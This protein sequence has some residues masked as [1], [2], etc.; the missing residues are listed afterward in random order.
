MS[1]D[2]VEIMRSLARPLEPL[3]TGTSPVLARLVGIRA[4]LLDVYGTLVISGSGDI[5][6]TADAGRKAAIEGA[7]A[8]MD[9]P[10]P[11]AANDIVRLLDETIRR[12]HSAARGDGVEFPEVDIVDV[13]REVLEA[14]PV[15]TP[16]Q[17]SGR[18]LDIERL[19]VEFE[20]RVNPVWPMPGL[21]ECLR[22]LQSAGMLL[23]LIS[24]A[25]FFT[26]LVLPALTG[27]TL[28]ELGLTD[29]VCFY[30]Y[31]FGHAKPGRRL[32][33]EAASALARRGIRP[34]EVLY[35]G[36]DM[37]N[38]IRPAAQIGFRTA[39]FAGDIRSLRLRTG[40]E[41]VAGIAPDLVV[42]ELRQIAECVVGGAMGR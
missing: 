36:N 32:F 12:R 38:D 22:E 15:G 27:R 6:T 13:W 21:V 37:L 18:G 35:A 5:G 14:L 40:D 20:A 28:G 2:L 30:S 26:A 8:A 33:D 39:L 24:N 23:G 4:V 11:A 41:R 3:P 17:G 16:G 10:L 34:P 25:Q 42:T 29:P 19:A 7:W 1:A 9:L 31:R